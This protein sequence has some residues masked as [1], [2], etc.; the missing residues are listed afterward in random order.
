[1]EN[2]SVDKEFTCLTCNKSYNSNTDKDSASEDLNDY[3]R[4]LGYCG[5]KCFDKLSKKGKNRAFLL[6][7]FKGDELKLIHHIGKKYIPG[8]N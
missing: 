6:G 4:Y 5:V 2:S 3:S 1:M 8:Y 7:L